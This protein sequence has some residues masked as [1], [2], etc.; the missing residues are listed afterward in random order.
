MS[1]SVKA[2]RPWPET[3]ELPLIHAENP[4]VSRIVLTSMFVWASPG[5]WYTLCDFT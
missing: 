3:W 4:K 5:V 2:D 1:R